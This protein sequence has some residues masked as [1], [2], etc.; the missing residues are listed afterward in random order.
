MMMVFFIQQTCNPI[1]KKTAALF[2]SLCHYRPVKCSELKGCRLPT[3]LF[4]ISF[5]LEL[6]AG[7]AAGQILVSTA[8]PNDERKYF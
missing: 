5:S 4:R 2:S 8:I 7:S 6:W 1:I 3:S